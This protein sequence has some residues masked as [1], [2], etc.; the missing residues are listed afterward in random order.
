[1]LFLRKRDG[2]TDGLT[3]GQTY[4]QRDRR[5]DRPEYKDARTHLVM[6]VFEDRCRKT[7][8]IHV[9]R[10]ASFYSEDSKYSFLRHWALWTEAA[11]SLPSSSFRL[12]LFLQIP[13]FSS[14]QT[15][16]KWEVGEFRQN[17]QWVA[18]KKVWKLSRNESGNIPAN[19]GAFQWMLEYFD[20]FSLGSYPFYMFT[21]QYITYH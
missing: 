17:F 15:K 3:D 8:D 1:M 14:R 12:L 10:W 7:R 18:N 20:F 21:I 5:I 2:P 19:G 11:R 16:Q 6:I 13:L 4:R 9:N